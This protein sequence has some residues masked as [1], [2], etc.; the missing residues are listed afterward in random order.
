M[1]AGWDVGISMVWG[2]LCEG[3]KKGYWGILGI[4]CVVV[5]LVEPQ[6]PVQFQYRKK[7]S[8]FFP[9]LVI[10]NYD[11]VLRQSYAMTVR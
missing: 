1:N 2:I 4:L 9:K 3:M 6:T 7:A 10:Q 8:Q 5:K 11:S